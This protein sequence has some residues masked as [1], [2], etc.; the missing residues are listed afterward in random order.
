MAHGKVTFIVGLPGSGKTT[1]ANEKYTN[2]TIL[3]DF[4]RFDDGINHLR[5]YLAEGQNCVVID[6]FLCFQQNQNQARQ[7][8]QE[9]GAESEWLFFEN[10]PELC[11]ANVLERTERGDRRQV[12]GFIATAS[13]AYHIPEGAIVREVYQP[14]SRE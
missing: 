11:L 1:L 6:P 10:R 14:G 3:D 4:S 9:W 8:M 13:K 5:R 12:A 2:A 7:W